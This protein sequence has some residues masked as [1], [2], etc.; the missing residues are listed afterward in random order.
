M[1]YVKTPAD[2]AA[3]LGVSGS[4][5]G[6][7]DI[8][9]LVGMSRKS[10]HLTPWDAE[11]DREFWGLNKG[12][13]DGDMVDGVQVPFMKKW[14]RWFEIHSL[15]AIKL[16]NPG[17]KR[18]WEW[19]AQDYGKPIYMSE[20]FPVFPSSI[21]YPVEAAVQ[22]FGRHLT[23]TMGYMMALAGLSFLATGTPKRLEMFGFEMGLNS[24]YAYQHG[25]F[26]YM[27]GCLS[28]MGV[29]I[30]FPEGTLKDGEL[31]YG[32]ETLQGPFNSVLEQRMSQ[33]IGKQ[34]ET[35]GNLLQTMGGMRALEEVIAECPE[36]SWHFAVK[37]VLDRL[38][39]DAHKEEIETNIFSNLITELAQA[40]RVIQ[41]RPVFY[42]G[43][44]AIAKGP[45]DEPQE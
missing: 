31:L 11:D 20:A 14:D 22:L 40:K 3:L 45:E 27:L 29:E 4:L 13:R 18:H 12:W 33:I 30:Y 37:G 2:D 26:M 8:V 32:Y 39:S 19:L 6:T 34:S 36:L 7:A 24:E 17:L 25:G 10:R 16:D 42:G 44:E 28:K 43:N 21:R 5:L 35:K 9:T 23:S 15:D 38:K 41:S 1:A